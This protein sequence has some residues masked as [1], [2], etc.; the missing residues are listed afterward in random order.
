MSLKERARGRPAWKQW[1]RRQSD[2]DN[3]D[4]H[5]EARSQG[6]WATPRNGRDKGQIH[7]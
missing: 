2:Y 6:T 4:C 7:L 5:H 1:R 3:G